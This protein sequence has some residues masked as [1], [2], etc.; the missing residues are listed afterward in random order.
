M[1]ARAIAK[2]VRIAP[3]KIRIVADLVRKKNVSEAMA[4]LKSTPK[5][6]SKVVEKVI[7]SAA[8]N[9]EHNNDMNVDALYISEIF[10]DQD[11]TM[12]RIHPRSRGQAF[13][14]LKKSSH[15]TVV[16]KERA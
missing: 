9:A 10:V 13:K 16:V 11:S 5:V 12:K 4:I 3:R 7:R 8:A 15:V 1:E 2:H 6:G 14:I